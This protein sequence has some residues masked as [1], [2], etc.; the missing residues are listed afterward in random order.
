MLTA[1]SLFFKASSSMQLSPRPRQGLA[2]HRTMR[3]SRTSQPVVSLRR[4]KKK[5]KKEKKN[6]IF[7]TVT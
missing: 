3:P 6:K 7:W 5:K 4:R 2:I 1:A